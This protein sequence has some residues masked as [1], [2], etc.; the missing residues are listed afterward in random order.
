MVLSHFKVLFTRQ[1]KPKQYSLSS[2]YIIDDYI[3]KHGLSDIRMIIFYFDTRHQR[4]YPY[5]IHPIILKTDQN[6][7][8][9]VF[10]HFYDS[11]NRLNELT[12]EQRIYDYQEL[13]TFLI[14][15]SSIIISLLK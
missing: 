11:M 10:Y 9:V 8:E 5:G 7:L 15:E 3:Q 2:L 1:S 6:M 13:C 12:M 14:G 4:V